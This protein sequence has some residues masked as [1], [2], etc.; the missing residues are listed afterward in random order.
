MRELRVRLGPDGMA[1]VVVVVMLG[2]AAV[3][4][5][6]GVL[7]ADYHRLAADPHLRPGGEHLL[8]TDVLGRDV[9]ARVIQGARVSIGAG[10]LAALGTVGI[11]ATLGAMAGLRGGLT[12]RVLVALADSVAAIPALV[13]LLGIGIALGP[14]LVTVAIAIA[15]TQWV[16][17][18]RGVRMES[19][20]LRRADFIR[21]AEAMGAGTLHQLKTHV[22]P[23]LLPLLTTSFALVFT[24]AV[25]AEAVLGYLGLSSTELPSWGRIMAEGGSE[26]ARGIWWPIVGAALPLAFLVLSVQV[27]ADRLSRDE[28]R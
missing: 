4:A 10:L 23:N 5:A 14:S 2:L 20:R 9:A 25:K 16:S 28:P 12:D 22:I 7:G 27:L 26:M 1:A 21:A 15:L 3:L 6:I 24:W 19:A 8:G 17:V 11:G 18:F 13:A